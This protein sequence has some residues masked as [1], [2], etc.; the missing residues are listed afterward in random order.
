MGATLGLLYSLSPI[1]DVGG[2]L[3]VMS[4]SILNGRGVMEVTEFDT[5]DNLP[6]PAVLRLGISS[7]PMTDLTVGLELD[8]QDRVSYFEVRDTIGVGVSN[9]VLKAD[10]IVATRLGIQYRI[11]A[12]PGFIPI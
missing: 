4:D 6:N 8:A 3:T 11:Q 5:L 1:V 12:G 2:S 7:K 10:A 9:I